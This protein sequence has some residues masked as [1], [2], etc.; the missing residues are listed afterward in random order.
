MNE[1]VNSI[2]GEHCSKKFTV[3]IKG[4]KS[5]IVMNINEFKEATMNRIYYYYNWFETRCP[6]KRLILSDVS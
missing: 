4:R 2:V 1:S 5:T 6:R 3:T